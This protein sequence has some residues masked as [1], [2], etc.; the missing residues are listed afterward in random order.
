[1]KQ[2]PCEHFFMRCLLDLRSNILCYA[3][4]ASHSEF[5]KRKL[6][7]V[8]ECLSYCAVMLSD[9]RDLPKEFCFEYQDR[10]FKNG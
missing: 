6:K 3:K 7:G 8:A 10:F 1:M 4:H 9:S 5:T 2:E